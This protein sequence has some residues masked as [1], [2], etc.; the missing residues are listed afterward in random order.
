M[1]HS[2][3]KFEICIHCKLHP[4]DTSGNVVHNSSDYLEC[5]IFTKSF[6]MEENGSKLCSSMSLSKIKSYTPVTKWSFALFIGTNFPIFLEVWGSSAPRAISFK[7]LP[8]LSLVF[9]NN[10]QAF[11]SRI[12]SGPTS[13]PR[14]S[15]LSLPCLGHQALMHLLAS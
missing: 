2:I 7:N 3:S 15:S 13:W 5:Q 4:E 8:A 14:T 10:V 9:L 6:G 1:L 11:F 12:S